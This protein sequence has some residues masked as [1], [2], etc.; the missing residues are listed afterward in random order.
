VPIGSD[1]LDD[2]PA[3]WTAADRRLSGFV[4][5]AAELLDRAFTGGDDEVTAC[6]R[7][8]LEDL[9]QLVPDAP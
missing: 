1:P 4:D 2:P 7:R 9:E 6:C 3:A 5:W 8:F